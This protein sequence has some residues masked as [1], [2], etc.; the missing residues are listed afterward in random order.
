MTIA[1]FAAPASKPR[2]A[3]SVVDAVLAAAV[4]LAREAAVQSAGPGEVGEHLGARAEQQRLVTHYFAS[5]APGYVGWTWAVTLARA[6]RAKVSTVCEVALL[7]GEGAILAPAWVPWSERLQPG[8]IGR[9]D[10]LP[11]VED[12][13]R[14]EPGFEATGDEDVDQLAI[15]ELGLGRARVLSP[16][17]RSEA[18]TRWYAG[19]RGP[20]E[21]A[22]SGRSGDRRSRARQPLAQCSTCGFLMLMAGSMR[23]MFGVCSNE[24]SPDDGRVV[25]MDHGCGAHSETDL[26]PAP[27][28]W[29]ESSPLIDSHGIEFIED[30]AEAEEEAAEVQAEAAS[31]GLAETEEPTEPALADEA[32][33]EPA[34]AEDAPTGPAHADDAL[35]EAAPAEESEA[36]PAEPA[37]ADVAEEAP[38]E[39]GEAAAEDAEAALTEDSEAPAEESAMDVTEALEAAPAE[40]SAAVDAAAEELAADVTEAPADQP[41]ATPDLP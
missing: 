12:D 25:S 11:Y 28:D 41:E 2:R 39:E 31:K 9:H 16:L 38:A 13:D 26:E 27:S 40:V 5:T 35:T 7:P 1:T 34:P 8:D 32:P 29:P 33:A 37:P 20:V 23:T 15:F 10:L 22:A 30:L 6:P 19:D 14:L 24:W 4:D 17:G 3:S 36:P 21:R 18:A